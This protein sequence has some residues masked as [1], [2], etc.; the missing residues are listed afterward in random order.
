MFCQVLQD[1][2]CRP[3]EALALFADRGDY[4]LSNNTKAHSRQSEEGKAT[5][6]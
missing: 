3:S 2:G 1:T 5:T 6:N 4:H